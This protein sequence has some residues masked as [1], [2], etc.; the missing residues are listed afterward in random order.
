MSNLLRE[1]I[2]EVLDDHEII[3]N[4]ARGDYF[5]Q[6]SNEPA[7]HRK[8]H[9]AEAL[10]KDLRPLFEAQS[11]KYLLNLLD[12]I[13]EIS[14]GTQP[15]GWLSAFQKVQDL[16][17]YKRLGLQSKVARRK[18][19]EPFLRQIDPEKIYISG[20]MTGLPD[21]NEPAFFEA[22]KSLIDRGFTVINPA[23]KEGREDCVTWSDYM[24][25]ALRD[26][27]EAGGVAILPGWGGSRG[28]EIEVFLAH[29]L[30]MRVEPVGWWMK[31]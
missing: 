17:E 13:S 4:T 12:E 28:S 20:P 18:K 27:A 6:C 14:S 3:Y 31:E 1:T 19:L 22:E 21:Y 2:R 9:Y 26:L 5:C 7:L 10:E 30:G 25:A 24:R 15:E 8:R 16:V 11:D 23:R 29:D